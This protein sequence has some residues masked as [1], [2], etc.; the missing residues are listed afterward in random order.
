[1]S[2]ANCIVFIEE[3]PA[4]INDGYWVQDLDTPTDVG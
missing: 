2:T 1:M 3:N 4:S